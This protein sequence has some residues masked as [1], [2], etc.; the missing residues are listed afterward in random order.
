[1]VWKGNGQAIKAPGTGRGKSWVCVGSTCCG[2]HNFYFGRSHCML[3]NLPWDF[4]KR[5][6][7]VAGSKGTGKGKT[8]GKQAW[9]PNLPSPASAN[10]LD[11][12]VWP[13]YSHNFKG[14]GKGKGKG[15]NKEVFPS[16][17]HH[18]NLNTDDMAV[19]GDDLDSVDVWARIQSAKEELKRSESIAKH[20]ANSWPE[21]SSITVS[22][23]DK[24]ASDK[25]ALQ[26]LLEESRTGESDDVQLAQ[27]TKYKRQP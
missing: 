10:G 17:P 9:K 20:A 27:K 19:D 21:G 5:P 14:S 15:K 13:I 3:C 22:T 11:S 18:F 25:Q 2:H 12:D 23:N 6:S 24:V 26:E 1:M 8:G 4:S 16:G 7:A